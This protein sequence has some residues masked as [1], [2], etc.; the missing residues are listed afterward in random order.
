[1]TLARQ[2]ASAISAIFIVALVGVQVIHL[3][4]AH[5][6]L[7]HQLESLAQDAATSLGLSLGA[8]LKRRRPGAGR[9]HH[10]AGF[11]PRPLRARRLS[12]SATGE[13]LVS[14]ILPPEEGSYPAWFAR[15]FPLQAPTAE[16]LVSA[17]WRQLGKVRVTVHP[18]FAYEQLWTTAR[19]T[20]ALHAPHLHR[21]DARAARLPARP[22]A[23][24][25]RRRGRGAGDLVPQFR[26]AEPAA[27][28]ARAGARRRGDEL[29]VAQGQRG[30]RGASRGGPRSCTRSPTAIR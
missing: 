3:R 19:D 30:D 13:R 24:A 6:H 20:L 16:S 10:Q 22:A 11:R 12:V 27:D 14:K 5:T 1:M 26:H 25:R 8:L 2:L 23:A 18:R 21:R 29:A 28:D 17:G 4:S 15:V 7:Q 9:D